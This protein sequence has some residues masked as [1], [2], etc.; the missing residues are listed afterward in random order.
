MDEI[1]VRPAAIRLLKKTL[2]ITPMH[3]NDAVTLVARRFAT[4]RTTTADIT[5]GSGALRWTPSFPVTVVVEVG[6]VLNEVVLVA[7]CSEADTGAEAS[8]S[9]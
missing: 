9:S 6:D 2:R 7:V 8:A 3:E 5:A 1:P 4:G